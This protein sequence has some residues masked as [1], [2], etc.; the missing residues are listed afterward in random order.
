MPLLLS[1]KDHR[2]LEMLEVS[3]EVYITFFVAAADS[4]A[5]TNN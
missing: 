2:C 1:T 4:K 3:M 5:A